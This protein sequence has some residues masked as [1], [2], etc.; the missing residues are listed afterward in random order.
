M[1]TFEIQYARATTR[2]TVEP[3]ALGSLGRA[4]A[5]HMKPTRVLMVSDET[6]AGLYGDTAVASLREAAVDVELL[7]LPPGDATKSLTSAHRIYDRLGEV[8]LARDGALVA[9]GGGMVS[10]LTG[11]VAATWMRGVGFAIC[12]TTLE[13]DVDASIGG[14][15]AVNHR[16]G[17]NLIGVFHQPDVVHIDPVC[18]Q[19]LE[20]RDVVA[21]LAESIKHA[22]ITDERFLGWHEQHREKVLAVDPAVTGQLIERNVRIKA[23][24]VARDERE[25]TGVRA[26]LNFGHT[27][28]HAIESAR[29]YALRHGECVGLGMVAA[30]RIC[31][32]LGLLAAASSDRVIRCLES[33][34][35]PVRLE[36]PFAEDELLFYLARDKKVAAGRVRFTLLDGL[37]KTVLRNDVPESVILDAY[38]SLIA[39]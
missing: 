29:G 34:G 20:R 36:E 10:D 32:S 23:D 4:L 9:L 3:G 39:H 31:V 11:F 7:A 12:P 14:K 19:T 21:G 22:A 17:K 33:Y 30:C 27:I 25:Q 8:K 28:G 1:S 15:T 26:S 18:L 16:A 6:V 2:V 13:A 37:G 24:V 35:L 38:R 5:H